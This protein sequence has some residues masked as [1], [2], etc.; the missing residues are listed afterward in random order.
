MPQ[1]LTKFIYNKKVYIVIL[2]TMLFASIAIGIVIYNITKNK[3]LI[4]KKDSKTSLIYSLN[5]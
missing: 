1:K 2:I 3:S 4:Q 5:A